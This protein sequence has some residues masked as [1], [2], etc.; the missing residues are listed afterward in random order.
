MLHLGP[1]NDV[2][3]DLLEKEVANLHEGARQLLS[4]VNDYTD[5]QTK[6]DHL[7][8]IEHRGDDITREI[9]ERLNKTFITPIEREDISGLAFTIDDV[10]DMVAGVGDRMLLYEVG[11]P[12]PEVVEMCKDMERATGALVKLIHEMRRLSFEPV[13]S[14]CEEVK[15]WEMDADQLYRRSVAKLLNEP[16]YDPIYV[17]KWKEIYEKL[18]DGMDFCEDVSNLVEGVILKNA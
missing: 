2:F 12:T 7:L 18:E 6:V 11:H 17:I 10:L 9:I 3:F 5:P 14:L 8:E 4:L 13:R 16:G 1:R 15:R